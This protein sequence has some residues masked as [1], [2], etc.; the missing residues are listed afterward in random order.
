MTIAVEMPPEVE[1]RLREEALSL[2]MPLQAYADAVLSQDPV[3]LALARAPLVVRSPRRSR[4]YG[5]M[6]EC[7]GFGSRTT[8][9]KAG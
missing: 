2:G 3:T 5:N 1:K 8:T 6:V 4:R 7:L 9:E